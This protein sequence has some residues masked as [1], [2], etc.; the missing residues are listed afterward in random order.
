MSVSVG[1]YIWEIISAEAFMEF[2]VRNPFGLQCLHAGFGDA[3]FIPTYESTNGPEPECDNDDIKDRD[4][5][6]AC[7][8]RLV[9]KGDAQ[10]QDVGRGQSPI[11]S[12]VTDRLPRVPTH[13]SPSRGINDA[14]L[15]REQRHFPLRGHERTRRHDFAD[16]ALA[17]S[18]SRSDRCTYAAT[19]KEVALYF[20]CISFE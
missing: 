15:P 14:C 16:W 5:V 4:N 1:F 11:V 6:D 20:K 17:S 12:A 3:S 8:P 19:F 10:F 9:K 18:R 2:H 13:S 7:T